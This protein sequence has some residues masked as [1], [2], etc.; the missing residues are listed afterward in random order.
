MEKR[1]VKVKD[2]ITG[3]EYELVPI[4]VWKLSPNKK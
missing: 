1:P 3:K 4:K 2:R